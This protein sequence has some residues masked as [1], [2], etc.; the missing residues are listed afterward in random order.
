VKGLVATLGTALTKD[1]LKILRRYADKVVLVFDS[2][3]AGQKASERGLD[4]LLSENVDIFVADLPPGLDTDD[5]ILKEGPGPAARLPGEAA[6]DLRLPHGRLSA[7][8]GV[9]TPAAKARI[10]EEMVDRIN[11]IPDPVK[12]EILVQQLAE[13]FGIEERSLRG[14][15]ARKRE[16]DVEP[17]ATPVPGRDGGDEDAA[18]AGEGGAR[19]AGLSRSPTRPS[20]AR[21]RQGS[22]WMRYPS[23]VLRRIAH[24]GVT[25]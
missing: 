5:V 12:Q 17:A 7:K 14:K 15:L 1:H 25:A 2:D 21:V 16:G 18:G 22:R 8:H 19:A 9:D 6:R 10:V 23:E 3:A 24:G 13:K 20:G 11:Q 4:L